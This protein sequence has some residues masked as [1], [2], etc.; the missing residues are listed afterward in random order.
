MYSH[1]LDHIRFHIVDYI[2]TNSKKFRPNNITQ[3]IT[4][5]QE[6]KSTG[7]KNIES[8]VMNNQNILQTIT[9]TL[10]SDVVGLQL[11]LVMDFNLLSIIIVG[12][13]SLLIGLIKI[14]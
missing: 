8:K 5:S 12:V 2:A 11:I 3:D 4:N 6:P 9:I 13:I 14:A 7:A 10:G 1:H